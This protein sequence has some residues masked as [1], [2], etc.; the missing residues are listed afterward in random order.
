MNVIIAALLSGLIG[1]LIS[2]YYY[3][4]NEDRR[5]KLQV[6][7]QLYG[8]RYDCLGERYTEALNQIPMVFHNSEKVLKAY[9]ALFLAVEEKANSK[10]QDRLFTDLITYAFNALKIKQKTLDESLVIGVF[11]NKNEG[12]F[13]D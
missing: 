10:K 3:Q 5:L 2:N 13:Q 12:M 8:N 1:V 9:E 4:R 7:Q 6:L 11:N